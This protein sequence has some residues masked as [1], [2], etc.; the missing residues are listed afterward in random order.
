MARRFYEI[1]KDTFDGL[2]TESG[3]LLKHLDIEAVKNG[4]CGFTNDD[5]ICA[6]TGGISVEDS[7]EWQDLGEDVDNCPVNMKEFKIMTGRSAS[8]STSAL[9]MTP[10]SLRLA[11]GAADIS[12]DGTMVVPRTSLDQ[13][14]DFQTIY[15]VSDKA[16]G[17]AV[18]A[19]LTNALSTGGMT[20]QTGKASKATLALTLTGHISINAQDVAPLTFYSVNP[21]WNIDDITVSPESGA[22]SVFDVPVSDLQ[23]DVAVA[24]EAITGTLKYMDEDNAITDVWGY[25]NFLVLKFTDIDPDA[26]SVKVGLDPSMGSG[27]VE[28]LDDPDK[29]GVFKISDKNT[30]KFKVVASNVTG[31]HVQTYDLSGLTI[32]TE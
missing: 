23:T 29:N 8:I 25:G 30:Q 5:I 16:N 26:T 24:N 1:K 11:L 12:E 10:E 6:T 32:E 22:T 2:V 19:V 13:E 15:W 9:S 20:V 4:E 17:G 3:L 28:I 7:T 31:K 27:L 14:K 18:I 21:G